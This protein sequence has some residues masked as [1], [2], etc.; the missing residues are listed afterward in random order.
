LFL[1]TCVQSFVSSND[2]QTFTTP[3][4]PD[5]YPPNQDCYWLIESE[6]GKEFEVIIGQGETESEFDYIEVKCNN[7][8]FI[9]SFYGGRIA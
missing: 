9:E 5:S 8:L 7:S 6:D 3:N 4:W 2:L 1:V